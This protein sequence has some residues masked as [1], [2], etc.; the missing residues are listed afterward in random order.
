ML[1]IVKINLKM[2]V[3]VLFEDIST[4]E[5]VS[6]LKT[7]KITI[8][9]NADRKTLIE[10]IT[11]QPQQESYLSDTEIKLMQESDPLFCPFYSNYYD[12]KEHWM[13]L[14]YDFVVKV[15]A[16]QNE[17]CMYKIVY[18]YSFY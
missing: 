5:I 12:T 18:F 16:S 7:H 6:F 15:S 17:K 4:K 14:V 8:P 2:N 11:T 10:V 13:K 1:N 3:H 9:P